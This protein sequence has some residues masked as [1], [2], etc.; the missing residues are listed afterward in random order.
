MV[1]VTYAEN[2]W[3]RLADQADYQIKQASKWLRE[4]AMVD[5]RVFTQ[6]Q[7]YLASLREAVDALKTVRHRDVTAAASKLRSLEA[8][9]GK[10]GVKANPRMLEGTSPQVPATA[11][12]RKAGHSYAW[13][14]RLKPAS[15]NRWRYT[16]PSGWRG[17]LG[18]TPA[19][20][21]TKT[22]AA[23]AWDG[24]GLDPERPNSHGYRGMK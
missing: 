15:G 21:W 17:P 10:L 20:A 11:L 24:W 5:G 22:V 2:Q 3:R 7:T 13:D 18:V 12:F 6:I 19:D 23:L 14:V 4:G 8:R 16:G 9:L 1:S